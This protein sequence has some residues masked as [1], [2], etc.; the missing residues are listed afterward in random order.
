MC[1]AVQILMIG[2]VSKRTGLP[3]TISVIC[4]LV[5]AALSG[6]GGWAF[7]TPHFEAFTDSWGEILYTGVLST[8]VAF[9]L[10]AIGQ[11]YVPPS[12]A[13]IILSAESLF[14]ALGGAV[15]LGERLSVIGY[16]GAAAIFLAIL[17][18]EAV[19]LLRSRTATASP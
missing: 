2:I 17:L 4:F 9:T 3:V 13:S 14:A 1:W 8:A 19:P 5:T 18:V 6:V 11:Q 15:I 16:S 10:Q 12:N 7:E